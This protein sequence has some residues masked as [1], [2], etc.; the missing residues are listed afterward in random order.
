MFLT[1][2]E[3]ARLTGCKLKAKQCAQLK[4]LNIPFWLNAR[5]QPIVAVA[6][7]NGSKETAPKQSWQPSIG[8][9]SS[10]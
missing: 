5:K 4:V 3:V 9:G 7:I 8:A 6:Y 10:R 1:S 2:E